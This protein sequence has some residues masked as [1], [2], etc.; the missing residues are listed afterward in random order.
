MDGTHSFG[1]WSAFEE[2]FCLTLEG[3]V[4]RQRHAAAELCRAGLHKFK[5]IEGIGPASCDVADAYQHGIVHSFPP[6]GWGRWFSSVE[7]L[8]RQPQRD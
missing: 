6:P 1:I 2:V 3:D 4:E 8:D 5:F 7:I